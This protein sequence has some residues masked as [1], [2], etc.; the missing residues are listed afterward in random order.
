M[1]KGLC[2]VCLGLVFGLLFQLQGNLYGRRTAGCVYRDE[3]EDI[4]CTKLKPEFQFIRGV[5][6]PCVY[7]C[8]RTKV[9]LV[10]HVD[11]VRCAGPTAALNR[12]IDKCIPRFCEIQAGPLEA[13]GV[14]V[15][16]LGRTKTRLSGAILTAPDPKHAKNIIRALG[17][18]P[19]E[20]SQVPS[21]KTDLHKDHLLEPEHKLI[22]LSKEVCKRT[23]RPFHV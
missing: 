18:G 6:E 5:K 20:K 4:L 15:E 16:V 23:V 1:V 19:K 8:S 10:H 22:T 2:R 7:R 11:D 17:I 3:L 14:A 12:P 13:E 21:R 9:T